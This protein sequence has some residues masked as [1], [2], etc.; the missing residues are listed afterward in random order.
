[1]NKKSLF[2]ISILSVILIVLSCQ[3]S[4]V[5]YRVVKDSQENLIK[6]SVSRI[7]KIK[8]NLLTLS[9]LKPIKSSLSL[10]DFY[11]KM[12][13]INFV[14][15]FILFSIDAIMQ[16]NHK[17]FVYGFKTALVIATLWPWF[18]MLVLF[19]L[20]LIICWIIM[21]GGSWIPWTSNLAK[22]VKGPRL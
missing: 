11:L 16:G 4:V 1:M 21:T 19:F 17:P 8:T 20:F 3:T 6:E 14:I 15:A 5:G 12:A 13:L 9:S 7:D 22:N 10:P 2:I 18:D